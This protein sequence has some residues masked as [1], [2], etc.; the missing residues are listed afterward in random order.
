MSKP[1]LF[2]WRDAV[3]T[4]QGPPATTRYVLIAL[5]L[6][7]DPKG[8]SCYPSTRRLATETG[9]SRR[10][11]EEHLRRAE[12]LGWITRSHRGPDRGQ[13]WKLMAYTLT[14]PNVGHDG[15]QP[16]AEGGEAGSPRQGPKVEQDV[17][18]VGAEG[19][20]PHAEGGES[21]DVKVGNVVP[22]STSRSPSES[23][24]PPPEGARKRASSRKRGV[25]RKGSEKPK[26]PAWTTLAGDRWKAAFGGTPNFGQLGR[27]LKPLIEEHGEQAVLETWGRYLEGEQPKFASPATFAAKFGAI[28]SGTWANGHGNGRIGEVDEADVQGWVR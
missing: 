7:A 17:P 6:H 19:G 14:V 8:G 22:L 4:D 12:N 27:F 10:S 2:R 3:R 26:Q 5:S 15:S 13:A 24:S 9:L 28:R 25:S 21:H 11:V 23:T 1:L 16:E 18:H 20:E